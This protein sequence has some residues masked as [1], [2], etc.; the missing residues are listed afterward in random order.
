MRLLILFL[1][2][3]S[4]IV[5][6]DKLSWLV[7]ADVQFKPQKNEKTGDYY[8]IPKFGPKIKAVANTEVRITGYV[9]PLDVE[10]NTY[11]LSSVSFENCYFCGGAGLETIIELDLKNTDSRYK[12]DEYKTFKGIMT[13]NPD[14]QNHLVYILK[15][16]VED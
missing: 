5:A 12:T 2:L 1:C 13:L 16:A 8:W 14:D 15:E 9:I 11:V 3:S 6:Q 7:M 4:A 10:K